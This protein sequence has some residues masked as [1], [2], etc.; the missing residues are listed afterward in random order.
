[1]K[2]AGADGHTKLIA[3]SRRPVTIVLRR[4]GARLIIF[5]PCAGLKSSVDNLVEFYVCGR[6]S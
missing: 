2:S 4:N 3:V 5:L 1:M 6:V